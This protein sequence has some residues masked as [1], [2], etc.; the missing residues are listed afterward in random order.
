MPVCSASEAEL[1]TAADRSRLDDEFS[2]ILSY[3]VRLCSKTQ[4]INNKNSQDGSQAQESS[5]C[6]G[7]SF[8]GQ[9]W[10]LKSAFL[11]GA[12]CLWCGLKI[13][14]HCYWSVMFLKITSIQLSNQHQGASFFFLFPFIF[15]R[16]NTRVSCLLS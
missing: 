1:R 14:A 9:T 8:S 10:I 12:C 2:A 15:L 5:L 6:S 3:T 13:W 7:T 11:P 16:I 4:Q